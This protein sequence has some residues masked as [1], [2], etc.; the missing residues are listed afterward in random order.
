MIGHLKTPRELHF[1]QLVLLKHP[2]CS[3][4]WSHRK[5]LLKQELQKPSLFEPLRDLLAREIVLCDRICSSYPKNYY[6]WTHRQLL[7][8]YMPV[9]QVKGRL[10]CR[11]TTGLPP[12]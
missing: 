12:H 2:K 1:N 7:S 6:A 11:A 8:S 9:V 10:F 4:A 5:W 3:E